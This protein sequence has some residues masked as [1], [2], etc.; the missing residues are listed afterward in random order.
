MACANYW[1]SPFQVGSHQLA[2][3]FLAAG[4][5][6]A[7]ISDP[8]SPLHLARGWNETLRARW[9]LYHGGGIHESQK[10]LWAYVPGAL[11]VP[12]PLPLLRAPLI[13]QHWARLAFPDIMNM[14][15]HQGFTNADLIYADS[16]IHW[17]WLKKIKATSLVYR[18][19]DHNAAFRKYTRGA[20]HMERTLAQQANLVAYSGA[21]LAD[22]VATLAPKQ[23]L[24]LPNGVDYGHFARYIESPQAGTPPVEYAGLPR[25][26]AVYVGAFEYWF[27]FDLLQCAAQRLP[28]V[29][30]VLI[31]PRT[32]SINA[33][34]ELA[35]VYFLGPRAYHELP[36]YLTHADVGLIPFD[37]ARHGTLVHGVNP[38]KL[39]EY[40]AC[41]LPVVATA[42][43][44]L[45]R[46]QS[47]AML[48]YTTEDFITAIDHA[49]RAPRHPASLRAY[50]ATHD[51]GNRLARLLAHL[52]K[53]KA[54]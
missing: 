42:W 36:A 27:D 19:A 15:A 23:T 29:T 28:G 33:L 43:R 5:K 3:Q 4:W 24:H 12:Q 25:P 52:D 44:E 39:Y 6:V 22:Y 46:L 10:N 49:A 9:R 53:K 47:P 21:C 8:I 1:T 31:G 32:A 26:L 38:L 41:G 2:R 18:V 16:A 35:N 11:L 14:L 34:S 37:V 13:Y 20:Q 48:A 7:F 45:E 40:L 30:F 17:S 51:W 54:A 50:A